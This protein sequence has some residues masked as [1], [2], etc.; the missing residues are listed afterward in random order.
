MQANWR[1]KQTAIVYPVYRIQSMDHNYF[2]MIFVKLL[3]D[4]F[5]IV[6]KIL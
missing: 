5:V 3:K 1:C 4:I 6:K 2:V